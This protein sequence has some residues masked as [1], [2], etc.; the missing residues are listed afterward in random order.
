[1][2]HPYGKQNGT[3]DAAHRP[4]SAYQLVSSAALCAEERSHPGG[5]VQDLRGILVQPR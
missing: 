5:T 1:M 2:E 4:S 3:L